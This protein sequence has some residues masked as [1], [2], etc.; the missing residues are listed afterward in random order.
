MFLVL[1]KTYVIQCLYTLTYMVI[2]YRYILLHVWYKSKY[3]H[4]VWP[5][6]KIHENITCVCVCIHAS[7][8]AYMYTGK[9][10]WHNQQLCKF[11]NHTE[12][13]SASMWNATH[14]YSQLNMQSHSSQTNLPYCSELA[15]YQIPCCL[16]LH[17]VLCAHSNEIILYSCLYVCINAISYQKKTDDLCRPFKHILYLCAIKY[18]NRS[19]THPLQNR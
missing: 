2:A 16:A 7:M 15:E 18:E 19:C 1:S 17:F 5:Q 6:H 9:L 3:A 4:K 12:S 10:T 14:A 8:C 11:S 13:E